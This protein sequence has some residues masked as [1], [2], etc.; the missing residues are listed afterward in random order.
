MRSPR[1]PTS[2][3]PTRWRRRSRASSRCSCAR[4]SRWPRRPR[5]ACSPATRCGSSS[6]RWP[7]AWPN[8]RTGAAPPQVLA[9]AAARSAS[10][11]ANRALAAVYPIGPIVFTSSCGRGEGGRRRCGRSQAAAARA[12][13]AG[14]AASGAGSPRDGG[15]HRPPGLVLGGR[16]SDARLEGGGRNGGRRDRDGW[17]RRGQA[18]DPQAPL[19]ARSHS[20]ATAAIV[21]ER[22][23]QVA[24]AAD[25]RRAA[26]LPALPPASIPCGEAE[27]E[28]D[29][30]AEAGR[31]QAPC[32]PT[33]QQSRSPPPVATTVPPTDTRCRPPS[34]GPA[35]RR[36]RD[37]PGGL[38]HR[39]ARRREARVRRATDRATPTSSRRPATGR[40]ERRAAH[41][42]V[43]PAAGESAS[44]GRAGRGTPTTTATPGAPPH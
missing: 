21:A 29:G 34:R 39:H 31:G 8:H 35:G 41:D 24:G 4:A 10:G 44:A 20:S 12:P 15:Q 23:A 36:G 16:V 6:G 11:R 43:A 42:A 37:D 30:E 22:P 38:V 18:G 26:P 5:R 40:V 7:R 3:S 19:S 14:P 32:L 9:T 25:H 17:S 28:R 2:R 1:C 27:G 33:S 13:P